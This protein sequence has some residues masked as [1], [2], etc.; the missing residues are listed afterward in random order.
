MLIIIEVYVYKT[1]ITTKCLQS[2]MKRTP[3]EHAKINIIKE[4]IANFSSTT[5]L[6]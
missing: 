1:L 2:V 6:R 3:C 5:R 4:F